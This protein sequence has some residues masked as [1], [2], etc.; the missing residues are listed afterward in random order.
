MADV[1]AAGSEC[2]LTPHGLGLAATG[3]SDPTLTAVDGAGLGWRHSLA[4]GPA[5]QGPCTLRGPVAESPA[6]LRDLG[7]QRPEAVLPGEWGPE[8]TA[9]CD[10]DPLLLGGLR[11]VRSPFPTSVSPSARSLQTPVPLSAASEKSA[12]SQYPKSKQ[13]TPRFKV[14]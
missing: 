13:G 8:S 4:T 6:P 7:G 1:T 14:A 12:G 9:G 5:L 10:V 11:Q 2:W 3:K